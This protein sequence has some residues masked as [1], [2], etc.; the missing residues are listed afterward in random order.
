MNGFLAA[1]NGSIDPETTLP[2]F[3]TKPSGNITFTINNTPFSLAPDQY[4][5]PK[6]QYALFGL[7]Q[8]FY[9][10]WLGEGGASNSVNFIIGQKVLEHFVSL[11]SEYWTKFQLMIISIKYSVYDTT[12]NRVGL[13]QALP[14][15]TKPPAGAAMSATS[16][17]RNMGR[18]SSEVPNV[19]A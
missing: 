10:A 15:G 12:N 1:T 19:L 5:V 6:E 2:I 7:N 13:A 8:T 4:L 18:P 14:K 16:S 11:L 3:L 9:Y 17:A